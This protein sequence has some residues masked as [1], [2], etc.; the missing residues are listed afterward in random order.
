MSSLDNRYFSVN[1]LQ[2]ATW[3]AAYP[4]LDIY[5]EIRK[6]CVWLDANPKRRKKNY[7]RFIVGW[8]NRAARELKVLQRDNQAQVGM[9]AGKVHYSADDLAS[10]NE[11]YKDTPELNPARQR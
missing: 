10:L 11:F 7:D 9:R 8:L 2:L 3:H 5:A 6:M 4:H 1:G